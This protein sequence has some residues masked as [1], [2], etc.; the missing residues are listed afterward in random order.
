MNRIK[1]Y[2]DSVYDINS[3][4]DEQDLINKYNYLNE[5]L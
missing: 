3:S 1:N 4:C 2:I 5:I